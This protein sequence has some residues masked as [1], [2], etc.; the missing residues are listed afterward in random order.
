MTRRLEIRPTGLRRFAMAYFTVIGLWLLVFLIAAILHG[1]ALAVVAV[2]VVA[3][4][5]GTYAWRWARISVVA[6]DEGLIVRNLIS[7]RTIPRS[8][9]RGFREGGSSWEYPGRAIRVVLEDDSTVVIAATTSYFSSAVER[10]SGLARLIEWQTSGVQ[11]V[12]H[13]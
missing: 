10:A 2:V 8:A 4:G 9:I 13:R 5:V 3:V 12:A 1:A 11:P 7:S 6:N